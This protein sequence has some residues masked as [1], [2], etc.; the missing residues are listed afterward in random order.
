MRLHK[1]NRA[2]AAGLASIR[3]PAVAALIIGD[4]SG[5]MALAGSLGSRRAFDLQPGLPVFAETG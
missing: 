5:R 4:E 1:K 3:A 2:G